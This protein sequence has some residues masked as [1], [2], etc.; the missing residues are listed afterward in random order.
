MDHIHKGKVV[1]DPCE[2]ELAGL[3][4]WVLHLALGAGKSGAE[5]G[6]G[7]KWRVLLLVASGWV[8]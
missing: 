7:I 4:V 5:N 3:S 2:L 1:L 8:H 6:K